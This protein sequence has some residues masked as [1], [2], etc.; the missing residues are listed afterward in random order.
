MEVS[1][2][3]KFWADNIS[4]DDII[5]E[6][7][8]PYSN[9]EIMKSFSHDISDEKFIPEIRFLREAY[10]IL[11]D[12]LLNNRLP[13]INKINLAVE[14]H[15]RSSAVGWASYRLSFLDHEVIP[16]GIVLNEALK[17]TIHDWLEVVLHE[18]VHVMDYITNPNHFLGNRRY[19]PHGEWF[20]QFG[21][22]FIKDGFNVQKFCKAEIG[23]N[24]DDKKVKNI[25]DS[26][27][28][29]RL[30]GFHT[31]ANPKDD[32]VV[33]SSR[34]TV[35]KYIGFLNDKVQR[36]ALP[37]LSGITI[38]KTENPQIIRLKQ[39]RMRDQ[40]STLKWYN[41]NEEFQKMYGP[42]KEDG[43][44]LFNTPNSSLHEDKDELDYDDMNHLDD[45]YARKIYDNIESV[46][47]IKKIDNE[48]YEVSIF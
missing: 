46:V 35:D 30:D 15:P 32:A 16:T 11:N 21:A 31:S 42:F 8:I 22:Q 39:L 12:K 27:V 4:I 2:L 14:S 24:S 7:Q 1:N 26:R 45:S 9:D 28:F 20:T 25:L 47:D 17:L 40:Y 6:S 5:F 33:V 29:L 41:F 18:M 43:K 36:N 3:I 37:G 10:V 48:V 44:V 13:H 23:I 19:D 34:S 38:L